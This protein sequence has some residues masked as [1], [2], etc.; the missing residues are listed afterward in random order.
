[1]NQRPATEENKD[2][3]NSV[4]KI[5]S[6]K[7]EE[8]DPTL[9]LLGSDRKIIQLAKQDFSN[10]L[11]FSPN[12]SRTAHTHDNILEKS[13]WTME[14]TEEVESFLTVWT[15][16]W[17]EKWKNRVKLILANENREKT[18]KI[19]EAT[20]K[21]EP[22]WRELKCKEEMIE[23]V[24]SA[25]I[26]NKEICGTEVLAEHLLKEEL[27]K[28]K[29][30]DIDCLNHIMSLMNETLRRA[31]ELAQSK[32]PLIFVKVDKGYLTRQIV[33]KSQEYEVNRT[34]D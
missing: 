29:S 14:E 19:C 31:R 24:L 32:G 16:M 8:M 18:S 10:Y 11:K 34:S 6:R 25:L 22:M 27:G 17:L 30:T 7:L 26:R 21:V 3:M 28:G 20:S 13:E 9:D 33:R 1:M 23:I 4:E 15:G 5:M 2:N 12:S